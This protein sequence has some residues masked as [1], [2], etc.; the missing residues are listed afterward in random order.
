MNDGIFQIKLFMTI[1]GRLLEENDDIDVLLKENKNEP[2]FYSISKW[3]DC[4]VAFGILSWFKLL[5]S[6]NNKWTVL[7]LFKTLVFI[8]S[9][10][11]IY[12]IN[13]YQLFSKP[14]S[15]LPLT[16]LSHLSSAS[17]FSIHP[18]KSVACSS[19]FIIWIVNIK[20]FF[21]VETSW[22]IGK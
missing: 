8:G 11:H 20:K 21:Y 22:L 19:H 2:I 15:S 9:H 13:V 4:S 18:R 7:L 3:W 6:N 14:S 1:K 5:F 10:I 12:H 17:H 16:T